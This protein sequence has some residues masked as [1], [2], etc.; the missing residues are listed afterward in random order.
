MSLTNLIDQVAGVT[1]VFSDL[2]ERAEQHAK[3]TQPRQ[4]ECDSATANEVQERRKQ[5]DASRRPRRTAQEILDTLQPED[6]ETL[7][8][9]FMPPD[10]AT[11]A[12]KADYMDDGLRNNS[13]N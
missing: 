1:K 8:N 2:D 5:I 3:Q 11:S 13:V 12:E 9:Y 10:N 4:A 6:Q 7:L